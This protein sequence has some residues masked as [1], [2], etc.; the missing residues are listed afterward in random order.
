[1][2]LAIWLAVAIIVTLVWLLRRRRAKPKV[3]NETAAS[4]KRNGEDS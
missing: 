2:G 1:M 3:A 4:I